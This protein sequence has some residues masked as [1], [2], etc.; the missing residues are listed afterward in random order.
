M[1]PRTMACAGF[2]WRWAFCRYCCC[3]HTSVCVSSYPRIV[4][5]LHGSP[6]Q[7]II[8][9]ARLTGFVVE[10]APLW[11]GECEAVAVAARATD[12]RSALEVAQVSVPDTVAQLCIARSLKRRGARAA[13]AY[14]DSVC[15][16]HREVVPV[17]ARL[18]RAALAGARAASDPML[19]YMVLYVAAAF[20]GLWHSNFYGFMLLDLVIRSSLLKVRRR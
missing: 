19:G 3:V 16:T 13:F 7:V 15:Y 2:C 1:T 20:L 4:T 10:R 11:L 12:D 18:Q 5:A 14:H 17:A 8:A 9:T 6:P